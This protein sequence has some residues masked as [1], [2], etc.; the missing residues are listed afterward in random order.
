MAKKKTTSTYRQFDDILEDLM[1]LDKDLEN[2][3][4]AYSGEVGI[5]EFT[6][7]QARIV[8]MHFKQAF[9]GLEWLGSPVAPQNWFLKEEHLTFNDGFDVKI[10]EE[11]Q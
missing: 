9:E 3:I 7:I 2:L 8:R 10:S 1:Q 11:K 5:F 4:L 6:R